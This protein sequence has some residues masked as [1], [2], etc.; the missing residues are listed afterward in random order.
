MSW[1][2]EN[3]CIDTEVNRSRLGC[4]ALSVFL[5]VS[6]FFLIGVIVVSVSHFRAFLF[7]VSWLPHSLRLW[8]GWL[9]RPFHFWQCFAIYERDARSFLSTSEGWPC[10]HWELF[11]GVTGLDEKLPLR[12]SHGYSLHDTL[13][14]RV[15]NSLRLSL[16]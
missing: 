7:R 10:G 9:E 6:P 11:S 16:R 15:S 3:S 13:L 12:L 8:L 5:P 4:I 1:P 2:C 14:T